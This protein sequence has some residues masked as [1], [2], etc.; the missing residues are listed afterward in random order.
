[1]GR[2]YGTRQKVFDVLCEM[3]RGGLTKDDL[4]VSRGRIVS[5]RK[6]DAAK[7]SYAKYGFRKRE[8]PEPEAPKPKRRRRKKVDFKENAA[9]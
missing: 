4:M 2:K 6:S 3:T 8:Q 9:S 5:K 1:M 7:A